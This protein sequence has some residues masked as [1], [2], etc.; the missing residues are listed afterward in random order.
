VDEAGDRCLRK[1]DVAEHRLTLPRLAVELD[2][3]MRRIDLVI[4]HLGQFQRQIMITK[5]RSSRLS[6]DQHVVM[7]DDAAGALQKGFARVVDQQ[8]AVDLI[9]IVRARARFR[10]APTNKFGRLPSGDGRPLFLNTLFLM[11]VACARSGMPGSSG[12]AI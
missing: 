4:E 7:E 6:A 11:I 8:I 9:E 5:N 12:R 1:D 2:A 3:G 10:K